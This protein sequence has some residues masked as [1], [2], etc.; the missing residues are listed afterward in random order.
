MGHKKALLMAAILLA[1]SSQ[2]LLTGCQKDYDGQIEML[3]N[4][5]K[6][7]DV[8]LKNLFEKVTLIEQQIATL[9]EAAK[10]HAEFKQQIAQLIA[11][12][13]K[14]KVE[15]EQKISE[16]ENAMNQ[17]DRDI[18]SL[19]EA[20]RQE[21]DGKLL[22]LSDRIDKEVSAKYNDLD[23]RVK[24]LEEQCQ[25][26]DDARKAMEQV[27]AKVQE[28]IKS[29]DA[30][31]EVEKAKLE[32]ALQR[33]VALEEK[34]D[35][36]LPAINEKLDALDEATKNNAENI[37]VLRTEL[38]QEIIA[39]KTELTGQISDLNVKLE[40][41]SD[42][43]SGLQSQMNDLEAKYG[44]LDQRIN[45]LVNKYELQIQEIWDAINKGASESDVA[46]LKK[47]VETLQGDLKDLKGTM[48]D[49]NAK[50]LE[51]E[52]LY[53][54]MDNVE[55]IVTD[56]TKRIESLEG[57]LKALGVL[58]NGLQLQIESMKEVYD[59]L[60]ADLEKRLATLEGAQVP[61]VDLSGIQ[62]QL[63]ELK[64]KVD[65][66]IKDIKDLKG[67]QAKQAEALAKFEDE[68]TNIWLAINSNYN[69]LLDKHNMLEGRVDELYEELKEAIGQIPDVGRLEAD[70]AQNKKDILDLQREIEE[71]KGNTSNGITEEDVKKMLEGY[72]N[73]A[74]VDAKVAGVYMAL[75]EKLNKDEVNKLI[76][77]ATQGVLNDHAK[78]ISAL[79]E[80]LKA[81]EALVGGLQSQI[82]HMEEVY[83]GLIA[84]LEKR[85]AALENAGVP[86][87]DLEGIQKL[88]DE[89]KGKVDKNIQDIKDLK[90]EQE[91][92][93][94]ALAKFGDE[95]ANIWL[96][97][98]SNYNDLL[99]K[100]NMLEGR[101]DEL[102]KKLEDAITQIPDLGPLQADIAQNKK[103]I[104]DLQKEI[105]ELKGKPC[106]GLTEEDV[107]KM[108]AGY[109]NKAEIDNIISDVYAALSGKPSEEAVK[110]LIAEATQGINAQLAAMEGRIAQLEQTY[111]SLRA[112]VDN[113]LNRIQSMTVIPQ[114]TTGEVQLTT[115]GGDNTYLLT[116][117]VK[118][119]PADA[120]KDLTKLK[121][122]FAVYSREAIVGRAAGDKGPSFKVLNVEP[123][124]KDEQGVFTLT[125]T[126]SVSEPFKQGTLP[127]V[128]A[129]GIKHEGNDR[130]T[131]YKGVRFVQEKVNPDLEYAFRS[132]VAGE[133]KTKSGIDLG[134]F[135]DGSIYD[136][137][138]LGEEVLS[139]G[140]TVVQITHPDF[141]FKGNVTG[142]P[143]G[144]SSVER[145]P[146]Q[147]TLAAIYN[148]KGE[149][150]LDMNNFIQV[151][152]NTGHLSMKRN[153]VPGFSSKNLTGYK[154]VVRIQAHEYGTDYGKP[155]YV[156]VNLSPK[157]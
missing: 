26:L 135:G 38:A 11:D 16:L 117:N 57:Q 41:V 123:K 84:D 17:N 83:D 62:K 76:E 96:A 112:D 58:V 18:K 19:I 150:D 130:I 85:L 80:Q 143:L 125:A 106:G 32:D 103:G 49:L 151:G 144:D 20:A 156:C 23:G 61:P 54:R 87:V 81:L 93:A 35:A 94:D 100:H 78:R 53:G 97:V 52:A 153:L 4:Q 118:V 9:Q 44:G 46:E 82:N 128:V 132:D 31:Q 30:T 107:E 77:E 111:N 40:G 108:L 37:A 138:V 28:E 14:T 155:A 115:F 1:G 65:N 63:D 33:L 129:V 15:L 75:S 34:L 122:L 113:L 13:T 110:Q 92:Q 59:G 131:E 139:N 47:V 121:S 27:V 152:P 149:S 71:L 89:L 25:F 104:L 142:A 147:Y 68:V 2:L 64:G 39:V 116:V 124:K 72:Y 50:Y 127:F 109:Y 91:K 79:E 36:Q 69:D 120:V 42:A 98:N 145:V 70:V 56:H 48:A 45:N 154:L 10:E 29:L 66:S 88:L 126:C 3:K 134:N 51:L 99:E 141:I 22:N 133:L 146:V 8:N 137:E 114:F 67:E 74:E 6:N 60:I 119:N 43:V 21:F 105:E 157:K 90:G 7:G 5:I 12:L 102:Y 55:G 73:K 24:K 136:C 95:V 101:V 86:P 148:E 140:S